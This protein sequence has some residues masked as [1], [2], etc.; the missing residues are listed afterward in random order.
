MKRAIRL[1]AKGR[2]RTSPNPMVGAVVVRGETVVGEGYHEYIGGPHAEVNA[3]RNAGDQAKGAVLYVTL[4]PC[5]HQGRTPPCTLAVL[6]AGISRVVVGMADPNPGV[7]GGG[8]ETLRA[9]GIQVDVGI[10]ER[11]CRLLNQA[12]IKYVTTGIP[13]V[14]LKA[15]ATLDGRIATRTGDA[16]WISNEQSRRFVHRLRCDLDGILVGAGTALADDPQ[17]TGRIRQKSPC[18]QPVRI[19]LDTHLK[20]PATA[21]LVRTVREDQ[22]VRIVC[23]EDAPRDKE[24]ALK[25]KGVAVLR[26]PSRD[27]RIDLTS[28]LKELGKTQMT[29]LLVEGGAH[30]FG[31]FLQE[32]LADDFYFFYASKILGDPQ[33]I[34][35]IWGQGVE[36]MSD[37]LRVYDLRIRRF[38]DD[39]MFAGRFRENIF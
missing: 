2:G 30:V 38:G 8:C 39:V 13:L 12:F 14:T 20:L 37:A 28:L 17:L 4:E 16:R 1:A 19:V 27:N 21:Q 25:K 24:E 9:R 10:L 29:S 35:M 32:R 33:G 34:P 22:P 23:G 26:L 5:N 6:E 18:R 3:L 11:E 7:R 15:A 31:A 36:K